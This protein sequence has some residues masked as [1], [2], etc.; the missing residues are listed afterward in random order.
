M[1]THSTIK[2]KNYFTKDEI[3]LAK[4]KNILEV[5]QRL[6][7]NLVKK[8]AY[9]STKEHDSLIIF[10]NTNSF[11]RY[12]TNQSGDVI[13]FLMTFTYVDFKTAINFLINEDIKPTKKIEKNRKTEEKKEKIILPEKNEN[14]KHLYAYLSKTRGIDTRIIDKFVKEK[15]I[16]E[17]VRRNVVFV[18][19]DEEKNPAYAALRGTNTETETIFKGEAENSNKEIGFKYLNDS[20]TL[21]VFES[22]IDMMSMMSFFNENRLQELSFL[23][24]SGLSSNSLDKLL[25]TKDF[26][27]IV[28]H[29]DNDK[30]GREAFKSL[31]LK[32][33]QKY[34]VKDNSCLYKDYKDVNEF[35][36]KEFKKNIKQKQN[37]KKQLK[38]TK[39]KGMSI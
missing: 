9:Y 2:E 12:S 17:D 22:P 31:K 8:G 38:K 6:N 13:N 36:V 5:A 28:F 23:S 27:T 4:Q 15:L 21:F 11:C 24:L 37:E 10:P 29:L 18:G 39:S 1:Y 34:I 19:Y 35:L 25:Q 32:Y 7:F 14:Y 33:E 26:K 30:K 20:D 3:A 16:Y